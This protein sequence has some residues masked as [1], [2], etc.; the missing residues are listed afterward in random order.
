MN[1]PLPATTCGNVDRPRSRRDVLR[2]LGGG[3][4][5]LALAALLA[6]H[7]QGAVDPLAS[8]PPHFAPRANRVIMLFMFGGPS[9]VDTFDPKPILTRD[10]GQPLPFDEPR[11]LS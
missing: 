5:S 2:Q 4:G 1:D 11:V 3:F 7:A 9:H 10:S 8:R 6:E